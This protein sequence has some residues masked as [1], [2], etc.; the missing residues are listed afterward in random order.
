[1]APSTFILLFIFQTSLACKSQP[2]LK[3]NPHDCS[4]HPHPGC[5]I[6][7]ISSNQNGTEQVGG[8]AKIIYALDSVFFSYKK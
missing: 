7:P 4:S 5:S 1:M 3:H 2:T 8:N 6:P